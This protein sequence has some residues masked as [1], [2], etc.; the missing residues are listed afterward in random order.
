MDSLS[1]LTANW[2][3]VS[4]ILGVGGGGGWLG[5]FFTAKTRTV[6]LHAKIFKLNNE[7]IDAIKED[8]EDRITCLR[9]QIQELT[10]ANNAQDKTI[11]ELR[12]FIEKQSQYLD[13]YIKKHGRIT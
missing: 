8:F 10:E 11:K 5:W 3:I 12:K 6:D 7:M 9:E 4:L 2:Q 13:L 1:I